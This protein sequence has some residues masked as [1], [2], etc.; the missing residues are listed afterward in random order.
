MAVTEVAGQPW[1][2]KHDDP[3]VAVVP[4]APLTKF[5]T[6]L[7]ECIEICARRRPAER[8]HACGSHWALSEAAISDSVFV[9]THDPDDAQRAMGR[10]LYEVVPGCLTQDF[11]DRLRQRRV[12][13]FDTAAAPENEGLYPMHFETGKRIYQAYAEL[14][15]GDTDPASLARL[16]DR[17]GNPDYLGPWAFR[18]LGGAGGQTVFGALTT[19][20]HGGDFR[21]PPISDSVMA[22]HLVADGGRHWWV[23]PESLGGSLGVRFTDDGKLRAL[24]GDAR[25]GGPGN[26][27]VVRDDNLF[28]AIVVSAGRFGIVYSIIVAA[29][30]QYSLHEERRLST[31]QEVKA[32][33]ADPGSA[34]YNQIGDQARRNRFLQVAVSVTPSA[35]F[36]ANLAGVTKR[37]NVPMVEVPGRPGV[38]AGRPERV[39][40]VVNPDD[41]ALGAPRFEFAGNSFPYSPDPVNPGAALPPNFLARACSNSR[42]LVGVVDET[43]AEVGDFVESNGAVIGAGIA[44]AAA[45]GAGA[46][47]VSLIPALIV[48]LAVLAALARLFAGAAPP[49]FG[50]AMNDIRGALLDTPDPAQRTAGL[51]V[52]HV[53]VAKV[54]ASQ[55]AAQDYGAISYAVM[56]GHDYMDRSCN[57]N[58]D[59]I[60]VFFDATDPML[61][62]W[63]DGLLAFETM[64]EVSF[65]R[66]FGGYASLRFMGRTRALIGPQRFPLSCAVEVAGLRDI[67][68]TTELIDFALAT[69]LNPNLGGT[70]HWGQRNPSGRAQVEARFGD[71]AA[72]AG[73]PLA[74]WRAAL[75]RV[76]ENGRL[77]GFSSAFTRR[78]GLEVVAPVIGRLDAPP[79]AR[80]APLGIAWDCARNPPATRVGLTVLRP[81]GARTSLAALPLTGRADVA[82]ED[83]GAHEVEL[84]AE[85]QV[86]GVRRRVTQTL[87]VPVT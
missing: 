76:S 57:L 43:I 35:N 20:T 59:S 6:S 29:V 24:Y 52:W 34:L 7:E 27:S 62:A 15:A 4:A 44:A 78:T 77:D 60:E 69:A 17:L 38:P 12:A 64:Q 48:I 79:V 74:R 18:T 61:V 16:L 80:P 54:F 25:Y 13:P 33:I 28:Q 75:G 47:L 31:W 30:R 46:L 39:G 53:I 66:A 26:F 70:L 85:L 40:R 36:S 42:F 83:G 32:Q 73:G 51:F 71:A 10:T 68:G 5:P 82:T 3:A 8:L 81:S 9:E 41:P 86:G 22:L 58:V 11:I 72:G 23:E 84:A 67:A 55:Q 63:I 21:M 65:G 87:S 37:W 1:T 45:L 49:R 2:R 56:D 19:G 14:D 50:Q